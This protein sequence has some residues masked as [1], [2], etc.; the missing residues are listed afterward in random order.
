MDRGNGPCNLVDLLKWLKY[1]QTPFTIY[2]YVPKD[3]YKEG[4]VRSCLL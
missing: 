4:N 2:M 3:F 1:S